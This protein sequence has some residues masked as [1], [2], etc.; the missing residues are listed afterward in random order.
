MGAAGRKASLRLLEQAYDHGIRHFD[1]APLY[2]FG[3]AEG[4]LGE[5]LERHRDDVTVT[6]KFGLAAAKN[7]PLLNLCRAAAGPLIRRLPSMKKKLTRAAQKIAH[8]GDTLPFTAAEA[9]TS[10]EHSL[11]TLRSERIDLFLLHEATADALLDDGLHRLLENMVAAGTIGAFGVGS[12]R[13][14]IPDLLKRRPEYCRVLQFEWSVFEQRVETGAAFHLHHRALS[15]QFQARHASL[16]KDDVRLKAW[17]GATQ[18]DL[19]DPQIFAMLLLKAALDANPE[20]VVLFSSKQGKH[21]ERNA[22]IASDASLAEPAR[23][24]RKLAEAEAPLGA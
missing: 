15:P 4:C 19:R 16:V 18:H 11:R 1:V 13:S 24:L 8:D 12:E 3:E 7:Q 2:G 22:R 20:S 14:R 6:T 5:F 9:K 21:I 17:C 23:Q 10:I